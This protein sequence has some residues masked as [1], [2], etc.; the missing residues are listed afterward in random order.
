MFSLIENPRYI[1]VRNVG[2]SRYPISSYSETYSVPKLI[3]LKKEFVEI[4]QSNL[5]RSSGNFILIYTHSEKGRKALLRARRTS[6][7]NMVKSL[8]LS[9]RV[10]TT[11]SQK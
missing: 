2:F 11:K 1:I 5:K 3:G 4:F 6:K 8:V 9:K 10:V 7:L